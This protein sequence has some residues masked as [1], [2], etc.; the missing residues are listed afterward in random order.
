MFIG[1]DYL[2]L[3][4]TVNRYG[5]K[6]VGIDYSMTCPAVTMM[7]GGGFETVCHYVSPTKKS[8]VK[9]G[10]T[11]F[12]WQG[13]RLPE[14]KSPEGRFH[15]LSSWAL[16]LCLGADHIFLEDYAM[17][18]KGRVFHIGENAG[19][20]KHKLWS[21]GLP[22]TLVSPTALKKHATGKGNADKCAMIAAFKEK[23]KVDLASVMGIENCGSPLSDVIDSWF[24]ADYGRFVTKTEPYC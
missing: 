20:L 8:E 18:A 3:C 10:V 4:D 1:V 21:N 16:P 5:V 19:V 23:T 6:I 15:A 2:I 7:F 11:G 17:G 9:G 14:Y 13:D 12:A 22:F 24:L